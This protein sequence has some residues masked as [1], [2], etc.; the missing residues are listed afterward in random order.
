[1]NEVTAGNGLVTRSLTRAE[2][3]AL[4]TIDRRERVDEV[5]AVVDGQLTLRREFYDTRGWPDGEPESQA[6]LLLACFERGGI[7][8]GVFEGNRLVAASVLDSAPVG[9][10]PTLRQMAFLHVSHDWRG[11]GLA[12][13]LYERCL[14]DVQ[15][16]GGE[17]L[18]ISATST[19]RTVDFYLT[20]GARLAP[21][22]D[23]SLYRLEPEDIH[24]IHPVR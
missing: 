11:H 20:K 17:G 15:A 21:R 5:Y 18:Y 14:A 1:M 3:P 2:L 4:W 6:P 12:S 19:R 13:A 24:L 10:W 23:S 7:F 22:P 9:D 8:R 16:L